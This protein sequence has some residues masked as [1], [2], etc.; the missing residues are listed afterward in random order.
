[1]SAL[2]SSPALLVGLVRAVLI[3]LV[4][5]GV[6]VTQAPLACVTNGVIRHDHTILARS[7]LRLMKPTAKASQALHAP[8]ANWADL[9]AL[10]R[11]KDSALVDPLFQLPPKKR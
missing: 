7:I 4:T 5:F 11:S 10:G 3:L 9:A 1:M 2:L 8:T 6:A